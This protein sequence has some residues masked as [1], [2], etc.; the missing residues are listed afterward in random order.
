MTTTKEA[1]YLIEKLKIKQY[2]DP[3]SGKWICDLLYKRP[4][5]W[6]FTTKE[7]QETF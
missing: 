5:T 7:Y 2:K 4:K 1:F 3:Q 6:V